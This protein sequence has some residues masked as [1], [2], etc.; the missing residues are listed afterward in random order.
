MPE[1]SKYCS[2]CGKPMVPQERRY[3]DRRALL[4]AGTEEPGLRE[5]V[6]DIEHL[7]DMAETMSKRDLLSRL[8]HIGTAGESALA[9]RPV[10][11]EKHGN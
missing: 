11:G 6:G 8:R 2:R 3:K 10:E 5:V 9:A 4:A 7:I 1:L